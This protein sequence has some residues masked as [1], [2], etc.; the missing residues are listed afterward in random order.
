M[1]DYGKP[2]DMFSLGIMMVEIAANIV[3]PDNGVYWQKL[4][5]GDLSD[6][7]QLSSGDLAADNNTREGHHGPPKWAPFFMINDSQSLDKI[8]EQLL[9]PIPSR[10]LTADEL[11]STPEAELVNNRRQAGAIVYEGAWGPEPL[12]LDDPE[13]HIWRR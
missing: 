5:S 6:A 11:L 13:M 7:G 8:V 1:G 12:M 9:N 3:P 4:R 2:A 10:R